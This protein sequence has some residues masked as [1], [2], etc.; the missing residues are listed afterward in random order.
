MTPT[1]QLTLT[2]AAIGLVGCAIN[3]PKDTLETGIPASFAS[4]KS[5]QQLTTC[6]DRNTDGINFNSLHTSIKP[7]GPDTSEIVIRN[8]KTVMAVVQVSPTETGSI[9]AIRLSGVAVLMPETAVKQM[10]AGCG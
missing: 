2:L 7:L 4:T 9:A 1:K 10:T 3:S 5:S 6:I 8:G